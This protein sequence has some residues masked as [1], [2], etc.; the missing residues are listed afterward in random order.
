ME[1][2]FC[3]RN[4]A[5]LGLKS[6]LFPKNTIGAILLMNFIFFSIGHSFA[7]KPSISI[8]AYGHLGFESTFNHDTSYA[9]FKLREQEVFFN[10]K[11]SLL[12]IFSFQAKIKRKSLFALFNRH[13][14]CTLDGFHSIHISLCYG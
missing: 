6:N 3:I 14:K 11:F 9:D 4:I 2:V 12:Y 5:L 7:Q 10:A 1:K 8:N 13:I